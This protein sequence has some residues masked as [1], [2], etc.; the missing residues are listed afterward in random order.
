MTLL[1]SICLGAGVTK[2][3]SESYKGGRS[4]LTYNQMCE[5]SCLEGCGDR[6]LHQKLQG[7][8]RNR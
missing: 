4:P 8:I 7:C 1:D 6:R 2:T 3:F 5:P